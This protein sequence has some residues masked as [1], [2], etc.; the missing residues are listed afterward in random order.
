[1][2]MAGVCDSDIVCD[3]FSGSATTADAVM[4]INDELG[5]S[6]QYIMIQLPEMCDENSRA[7]E[8]GYSNICEIGKERIRRAGNRY[9]RNQKTLD[10]E[11]VDTG[12]RVFKVDSSNMNDVFYDPS[13]T[14]KS[15]L[16]YAAENIKSDRSG[17]D[18]LIQVMLEL[19]VELSADI[20][21]ERVAGK[22]VFT[23]DGGYLVA[24]FD[25]DVDDDLVTE[26][27]KRQP[28]YAVFRDSSMSSD[29]V[30]INFGEIFKTFSPDTQTKVL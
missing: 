30:A 21:E 27:A 15:I 13:A 29:S 1:M 23:V 6:V 19:G 10:G 8:C 22:T 5:Y 14:K 28:R 26:I 7:H 25:P 9:R 3:F 17:Q 16:D 24:C 11:C 4:R 20:R 12:F 18:L 2:K